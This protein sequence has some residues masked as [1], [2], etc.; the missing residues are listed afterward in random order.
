MSWVNNLLEAHNPWKQLADISPVACMT[1][2]WPCF[3]LAINCWSRFDTGVRAGYICAALDQ[4]EFLQWN[5]AD[6]RSYRNFSG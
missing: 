1:Q 6:A 4:K 2:D 3:V 5:P